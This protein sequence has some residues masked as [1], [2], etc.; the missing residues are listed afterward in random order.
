MTCTCDSSCSCSDTAIKQVVSDA[1]AA[2]AQSFS[3][4]ADKAMASQ[5]AAASSEAN[6]ANSATTAKGFSDTASDNA[7]AAASSA[8]QAAKAASAAATSAGTAYDV[9]ASLK[10]TAT[11][12]EKTAD[13]LSADVD[14]VNSNAAAIAASVDTASAYATS[15]K[16]SASAAATSATAAALSQTASASNLAAAEAASKTA[17]Q[18]SKSAIEQANSASSYATAAANSATKAADSL[19]QIG[20]SVTNTATNATNAAASQIAAA[21]SA[22]TA[23]NASNTAQ[24][25]ALKAV[26]LAETYQNGIVPYSSS[27]AIQVTKPSALQLA[28]DST[29]N[30]LWYWNG[31][32]WTDLGITV[33]RW[34]LN[35][36]N[37]NNALNSSAPTF[38]D[39]NNILRNTWAGIEAMFKNNVGVTAFADA[40]TLLA[41]TPTTANVLAVDAST[42]TYYY[43]NGTAWNKNTYQI[44]AEFPP[45]DLA[46]Q[47]L[48]TALQ[49]LTVA[50][51]DLSKQVGYPEDERL[52]YLRELHYT[53]SGL[54]QLDGF[55]PYDL[56]GSS[57][58]Q[59]SIATISNPVRGD[60]NYVIPRPQSLMRIDLNVASVPVTKDDAP[61]QGTVVISV[62]GAI[63]SVN[64]EIS[65]QG[66]TSAQYGKK[67]LNIEFFNSDR[68]DNVKVKL[69]DV[70]PLDTLT[71]K[72]N[73]IDASHCRNIMN[74]RLWEQIVRSRTSFPQYET[75]NK[76]YGL[77]GTKGVLDGSKGFPMGYEC[78]LYV[79]GDFYGIGHLLSGKKRDSYAI[80]KNTETEILLDNSQW[81]DVTKSVA[82]I[83]AGNIE[84]KAPKTV[85]SVTTQ[86]LTNWDS[87]CTALIG[88]TTTNL[89]T[90]TDKQ[91]IIDFMLMVQF[92]S[93]NDLLSGN[94]IKNVQV[95]SYTGDKWYFM[96]YDLD[97]CY[98][99]QWDGKAIVTPASSDDRLSG[100]FWKAV[101]SGYGQDAMNS[102]YAELRNNNIFTVQ[103]IARLIREIQTMFPSTLFTMEWAKWAS[104]PSI[105]ITSASQI[106]EWV[107][108]RLEF[109]DSKYNYT[110]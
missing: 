102:R 101:I 35:E 29:S 107:E 67:N 105:G 56:I 52:N 85:T 31:T 51:A 109:L 25:A 34:I 54:A 94:S 77:Y 88:G 61:V 16:G 97:T 70:M 7:T 81:H 69:G 57:N 95:F 75:D 46:I 5:T 53:A 30:E 96:P 71:F 14:N 40:T 106:I 60:G 92:I 50:N 12:L 72:A 17:E 15:A 19:N 49:T 64:C 24:S 80:N 62:D 28:M 86:K 73:W 4:L 66:N 37:L 45:R 11:S 87:F 27:A 82:A 10:A 23:A 20:A 76:F 89:A 103:N 6:A 39:A 79:N 38:T 99:L 90:M 13:T 91:N 98:G 36:G 18:S 84:V 8:Q 2:Q 32:K 108:E 1:V 21:A 83:T 43:W 22:V 33:D 9:T 55:D 42:G 26:G 100:S 63:T 44:N 93:A 110:A 58:L 78:V 3:D 47:C 104:I 59:T 74:Y 41:F 65:V 68:S 48:M